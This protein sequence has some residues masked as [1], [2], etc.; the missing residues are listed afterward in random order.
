MP[1]IRRKTGG[2][3]GA[4]VLGTHLE[5][6]FINVLKKGAHP[7]ECIVDFENGFE[8]LEDVYGSLEDVAIVTLAPEIKGADTVISRL[9]KKGVVISLGHSMGNLCHGEEAVKQGASFITHL[10]NAMLPFHHRE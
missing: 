10:F 7:P 6:P 2:L 4:T 3:H 5:G 1:K 9:K 8:T